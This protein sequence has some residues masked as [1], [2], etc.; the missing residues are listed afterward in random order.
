VDLEEELQEAPVA[1]NSGI[2]NNFN[3]FGMGSV[4]AIG[5]VGYVVS[6]AIRLKPGCFKSNRIAN[7]SSR[8]MCHAP[9]SVRHLHTM[10]TLFRLLRFRDLNSSAME[11]PGRHQDALWPTEAVHRLLA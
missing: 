8:N 6:A 9:V 2:K 5:C 1:D 11:N 4:I 3:R 10:K 7:R